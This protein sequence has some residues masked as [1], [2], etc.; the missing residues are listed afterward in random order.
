MPFFIGT[1]GHGP[2]FKARTDQLVREE[3]Q[4][5]K[6]QQNRADG[7]E[8]LNTELKYERTEPYQPR[9][10]SFLRRLWD[11]LTSR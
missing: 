5:I 2:D 4:R 10:R 1:P 11:R 7:P 9:R 6:E 3:K 8:L